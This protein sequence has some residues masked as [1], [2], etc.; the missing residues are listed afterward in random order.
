MIY[1]VHHSDTTVLIHIQISV[2]G[3]V[4]AQKLLWL[5]FGNW[6]VFVERVIEVNTFD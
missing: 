2:Y 6:F 3:L 5:R 1:K 4:Q